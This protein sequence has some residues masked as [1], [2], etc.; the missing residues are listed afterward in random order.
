[1][2]IDQARPGAR[3]GIL[4]VALACLAMLAVAS[5]PLSAQRFQYT[6]GGT[7]PTGEEG[8]AV[9]QAANGD[10]ITAGTSVSLLGTPQVYVIRTD[11]NGNV[12]LGWHYLYDVNTARIG[13][14][15][16][17]K[18]YPNGDLIVVGWSGP[19]GVRRAFAMRLD[20]LGNVIW[21]RIV[22]SPR[23]NTQANSV[24]IMQTGAGAG[25]I[26]IGGMTGGGAGTVDGMLA[27]LD[28][29][30]NVLWENVYALPPGTRDDIIASIDEARSFSPGDIVAVGESRNV[31]TGGLG[32]IWVLRVDGN[33]NI[34]G[35]VPYGS[36]LYGTAGANDDRVKAAGRDCRFDSCHDYTLHRI[37]SDQAAQA[38]SQP[39]VAI[40][41]NRRRPTGL[42]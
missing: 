42:M 10:I 34:P 31:A 9:I 14:A 37:C 8:N 12:A 18:E 6:F 16:D 26:V 7:N 4:G 32:D 13:G 28:G 21:V 22:G 27:R 3:G 33:G 29:S 38:I 23:P 5:M 25:D 30:G 40:C 39:M 20:P 2:V 17:I 1:M 35:A 19:V 24:V 41:R 15:T 36:A 11:P